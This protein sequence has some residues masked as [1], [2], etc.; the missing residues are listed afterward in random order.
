MSV[1][2][3]NANDNKTKVLEQHAKLKSCKVV[4]YT[5]TRT[6]TYMH[7]DLRTEMLG[8]PTSRLPV[9]GDNKEN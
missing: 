7:T 3:V 2:P 6:H 9:A 5:Y 8:T 1:I 4:T